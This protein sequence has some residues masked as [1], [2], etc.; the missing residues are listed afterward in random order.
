MLSLKISGK[1]SMA[2]L[3]S[4]IPYGEKITSERLNR[5]AEAEKFIKNITGVRQL[6]ARD[7]GDLVR[8]EVDREERKL[9]FNEKLLDQIT[10]RMRAIGYF[11]VTL[12]LQG[13]RTGSMD[14]TL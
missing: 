4:R 2:C 10:D 12:D 8:I 1:P 5:I 3:S 7:H 14:E 13:Y 9:F 11:Y 6:R